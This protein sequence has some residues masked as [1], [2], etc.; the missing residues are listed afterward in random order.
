MEYPSVRRDE[1]FCEELHGVKVADP[2]RWLED[3]NSEETKK[4]VEDQNNISVPYLE[5]CT[6]RSFIKEKMTE[7]F[8]HP[9]YSCPFKEGSH[10]FYHHNTGLQNQSVMF[11]MDSLSGEPVE[12]LNPNKLSED[13][14]VSL[15]GNA[16]TEDGTI[17]AYKL[18]SSGSDWSNIHFKKVATMEDY[19][20]V[21][22]KVKVT[23][24][25]WTHDNVGIFYG[26]YPD[27]EGVTDGSETTTNM[28]QKLMYHRVGTPQSKDVLVLEWPQEP[29][30]LLGS[31][32]V[33]H[34]GR[35]L[36]VCPAMGCK[37]NRVSYA[38]IP[39]EGVTGPLD[40]VHL[41]EEITAEYSYITN[42]GEDFVFLTNKDSP[43][44]KLIVINLKKPKQEEWRDLVPH[45]PERVLEWVQPIHGD[46][47]LCVV[48][49]NVKNVL[50]LRSLTSGD[51]LKTIDLEYGS[52]VGLSGERK[53]SELFYK[54]QSKLEPAVIYHLDLNSTPYEPKVF[55]RIT[56][57]N[58][59]PAKYEV[60]QVW[61]SSKDG[62][63]VPMTV[64]HRKGLPMNGSSPCF[65]YGYGGFNVSLK[66]TF[67]YTQITFMRLFN[68]VVAIPNLRGG[69]EFGDRWHNGGRLLNKQNVFDDFIAAAEHLVAEGYTSADKLTI[70][71]GSNG[72]LLTAACSNQR[73]ELFGA[74]VVAVGVNDMLRFHRFTIGY[75]WCS[76]Y[77]S[78]DEEKHFRNLFKFSPYHNVAVP[79]GGKHPAMLLTTGDHDDR[80]VPLHSYKLV[81][82]LQH[83][84]GPL[85]GAPILVR[86]DTKAGHG[87]GKPT[88]KVIE[89]QTDVFCF[90]MKALG[91]EVTS[92]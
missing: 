36:V 62:T 30:M 9:K 52:I 3:E 42:D 4:F 84:L 49:D 65:L 1:D 40:F 77:G 73:P 41:I 51:L 23:S 74:A 37:D 11:R 68:G 43:N 32:E 19:P 60:R 18:S 53:Q 46:K 38:R 20:E 2:Y 54:F 92:Y 85:K 5:K 61:Y 89:E 79:S 57:K 44:W 82:A 12:Y 28:S 78:P 59:D 71:G 17:H 55:R 34:C 45:H 16:F 69:G 67:S 13:G 76:D 24:M 14:T 70:A 27:Q 39:E 29:K 81:S 6:A 75:L 80:V 15:A 66:P 33:S 31:T 86:V 63:R 48:M 64:M 83:T 90:M 50:E 35:Y 58:L 25:S 47:M 88:T 10:Y 87:G 21:L 91:L 7:I 56:P 8:D 72:G 26:C 22:E